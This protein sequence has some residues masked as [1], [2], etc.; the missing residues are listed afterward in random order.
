ML[1][2]YCGRRKTVNKQMNLE[3]TEI[4][5]EKWGLVQNWCINDTQNVPR[6]FLVSQSKPQ[7]PLVT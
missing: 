4:T 2:E 5:L 3:L 6:V 7:P 1:D